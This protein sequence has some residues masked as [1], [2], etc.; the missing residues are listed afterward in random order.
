[1]KGVNVGDG[2]EPRRPEGSRIPRCLAID[3]LPYARR[4]SSESC[5]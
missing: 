4:P 5:C 3:N 1:V 2:V